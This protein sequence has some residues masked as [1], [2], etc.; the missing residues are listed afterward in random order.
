MRREIP[1]LYHRAAQGHG[2]RRTVEIL[3]FLPA[4][5]AAGQEVKVAEKCWGL[6]LGGLGIGKIV[7]LDETG[8]RTL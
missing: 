6:I 5:K 4:A 2:L 7:D 1:G 8:F 3:S